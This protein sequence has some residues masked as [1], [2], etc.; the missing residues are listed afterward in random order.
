MVIVMF[1]WLATHPVHLE[2][3]FDLSNEALIATSK[4][5]IAFVENAPHTKQERL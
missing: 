4:R 3:V 2:I 1:V 5:F